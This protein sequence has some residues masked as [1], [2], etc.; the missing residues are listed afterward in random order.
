MKNRLN[1]D[2]CYCSLFMCLQPITDNFPMQQLHEINW[3][4]CNLT[5]PANYFHALRRQTAFPFRKPLIIMSPKSL[6]RHPE[7]KST[8]DDFVEGTEFQ[9]VITD[10][11]VAGQNPEKVK[12]LLFCSG[13]VFYDLAKERINSKKEKDV[14][15]IRLEQVNND[16]Q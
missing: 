6:L 3:I 14:A 15:I 13:K 7:A 2:V 11:T 16:V 5:T 1:A 10:N 8:F 4:V 9:R 12:K